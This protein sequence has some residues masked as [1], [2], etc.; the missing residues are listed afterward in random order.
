M[1]I[2]SP[3]ITSVIPNGRSSSAAEPCSTHT[4]GRSTLAISSIGRD[5]SAASVSARSSV[6]AFGTSSPKTTHR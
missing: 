3:A 6:S 1:R 4:T 5:T 2:E